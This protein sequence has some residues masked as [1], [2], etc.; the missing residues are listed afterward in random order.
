M[1]RR[2]SIEL[3]MKCNLRL[4]EL[5]FIFPCSM[6]PLK[7]LVRH[8]GKAR[9]PTPNLKPTRADPASSLQLVIYVS[10]L[11]APF[12]YHKMIN[13]YVVFFIQVNH[14]R[15]RGLPIKQA[16][17]FNDSILKV[18]DHRMTDTLVTKTE[19]ARVNMYLSIQGCII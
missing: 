1:F 14:L 13:F 9:L 18:L 2:N 5:S 17:L 7:R 12:S 15:S 8:L 3:G 6:F 16:D 10:C 4:I 11:D 19:L